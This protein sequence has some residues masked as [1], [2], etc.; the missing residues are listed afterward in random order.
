MHIAVIT[1]RSLEADPRTRA[2]VMTLRQAGNKVTMVQATSP[3]MLG[4]TSADIEVPSRVPTG[5]TRMRRFVRG[6]QSV[7]VR[8]W[9]LTRNLSRA[10]LSTGA[11]AFLPTTGA[12]F[13]AAIAAASKSGGSVIRRPNQPDCGEV[14][15][16]NLAPH[17]PDMA[18]PPAGSGVFHTEDDP[19]DDQIPTPGSHRGRKVVIAYRK[20]DSNPGKYLEEALRRSGATV[21]L[22]TNAVD[23]DTVDE[24]TDFVVFVEGPYPALEIS[25][26]PSPCPVLLWAHHGEHHLFANIRLVKRY[27]ADAVL[28][29]HSWHMA[30]WFPVPVHR[31]PFGIPR[32]LFD[33]SKVLAD[34]SY[35]VGM[36]G[37]KLWGESGPYGRRQEIVAQLEE[38]FPPEK[39]GFGEMVSAAE[40]ASLYNESRLIP[41]EGGTRHY[42]I[43]MR[44]FESIAARAV[45]ISDDLPGTDILFERD[46]H[47]LVLEEDVAAQ[48][49]RLLGDIG[50][51]QEIADAAHSRALHRHTYDHRVDELFSIAETTTPARSTKS[52][53]DTAM[54]PLARVIDNDPEVQRVTHLGAP[55]L[56]EQLPTREVLDALDTEPAK[57]APAKMESVA[58][59][60]EDLSEYR[61]LLLA[62][63]RYIYTDGS[64]RGL[65]EFLKEHHPDAEVESYDDVTRVDLMA[66]A[67]RILP[68]E[69]IQW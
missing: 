60:A 65:D 10:A 46:E 52:G 22:E 27:R 37:A 21:R 66:E 67:Y 24:D 23:F 12:M 40:M 11:D 42:P 8:R 58:I 41:N 17:R 19:R 38:V 55:E 33:P 45:L 36:V 62:A 6:H 39:L 54:S 51:L 1:T 14:D 31:F 13:S 35:D 3:S 29:A 5:N 4:K 56:A 53:Q 26:G 47:W 16:I 20:T 30:P 69:V 59:R 49:T 50:R 7:D 34:R 44:V 61:D 68:H 43:T 63:R 18:E 2:S 28:L 57:L 9:V 15:L 32:E 48:A 25:G 64:A